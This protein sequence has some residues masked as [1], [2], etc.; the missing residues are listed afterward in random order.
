MFRKQ[1]KELDRKT[2]NWFREWH[3]S[4]F[5][6]VE[7]RS[8]RNEKFIYLILVA[9]LGM[10]TVGNHYHSEIMQFFFRLFGV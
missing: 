9:V 5:Q 7:S 6:S 4:Y 1:S 10:N 2:P 3:N 8:K